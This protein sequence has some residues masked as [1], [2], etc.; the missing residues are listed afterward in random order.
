VVLKR[1]DFSGLV[2]AISAIMDAHP[3]RHTDTYREREIA[4]MN[5]SSEA[6]KKLE[7]AQDSTRQAGEI[8]ENLIAVHD[9]QD[10]A[11]VVTQAAEK[12][13]EAAH[14]LMQSDDEAA[15]NAIELAEDLLDEVYSV[16]DADLDE[17]M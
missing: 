3:M 17:D 16:I 9:Y 5:T 1:Q 6:V 8:I 15:L 4:V 13:L 12:L 7:D 2:L 11:M 14:L 10:V